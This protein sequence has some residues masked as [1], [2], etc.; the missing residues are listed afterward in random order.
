[1]F[2]I[3]LRMKKVLMFIILIPIL[4]FGQVGIGTSTPNADAVLELSDASRGLLLP[5]VSLTNTTNASPLSGHVAGMVVYNNATTGD[6]V[7]G[8]YINDGSSWSLLSTSPS[9]EAVADVLSAEYEGVVFD[10]TGTNGNNIGCL[11]AVNTGVSNNY[12]NAYTWQTSETSDQSYNIII[13]Y[14]VPEDFAS[15]QTDWLN[16]DYVMSHADA[17]LTLSVVKEDNTS[18]YAETTITDNLSWTTHVVNTAPVNAIAAG[19]ILII[20]LGLTAN[21][22]N[23]ASI[24]VSDIAFKYNK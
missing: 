1:M 16:L 21:N 9:G 15:V 8:F 3:C 7:P 20:R 23:T 19:D 12:R 6:V 4:S 10:S 5:R 18:V 2:E 17:A 22:T 24:S 11:S 13:R 14:Q